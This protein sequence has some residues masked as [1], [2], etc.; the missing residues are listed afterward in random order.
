MYQLK[1]WMFVYYAEGKLL[2]PTSGQQLFGKVYG[3]PRFDDGDKVTTSRIMEVNGKIVKT[4]SGSEYELKE[5]SES[6]LELLQELGFQYDYSGK[7]D[8]V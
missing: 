6:F 3:H 8:K 1:D 4:K 2:D 5:P 7:I